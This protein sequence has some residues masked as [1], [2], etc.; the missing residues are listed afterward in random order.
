MHLCILAR[1]YGPLAW[2]SLQ[3]KQEKDEEPDPNGAKLRN[4]GTTS[5]RNHALLS[6]IPARPLARTAPLAQTVSDQM[7]LMPMN[8]ETASSSRQMADPAAYMM[9][10]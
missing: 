10:G 2:T 4:G 6:A 1:M 7:H 8:T 3:S 5:N 9:Y